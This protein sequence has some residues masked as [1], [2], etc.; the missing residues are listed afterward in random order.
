MGKDDLDPRKTAPGEDKKVFNREV[1]YKDHDIVRQGDEAFRAYFIERGRVGIFA[2]D[3]EHE[4]KIAELETGDIFG[5]MSLI[6]DTPR[7]A[8]ARAL[9]ETVVTVISREALKK[10]IARLEDKA[11]QALI[12]VLSSRLREATD[13]QFYYYRNLSDFQHRITEII[14]RVRS[15]LDEGQREDLKSEVSPLLEDLQKVLD[16]YQ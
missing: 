11:V 8:T 2:Q 14:D 7:S 15:G 6:N 9:E 13:T 16:R 3:K 10:K 5:E 12:T 1:Y 4:M